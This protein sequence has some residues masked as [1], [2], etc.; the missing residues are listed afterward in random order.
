MN[1]K[2]LLYLAAVLCL[3][4]YFSSCTKETT[5]TP[6]QTGTGKAPATP[7]QQR[8]LDLVNNARTTGCQCGA[9]YYPA[10]AAVTWHAELEDAAKLHSEYMNET[11][12]LSHTGRNNSDAGTRITAAGYQWQAYGENIAEGY[13]TE[14]DVMNAWLSSPGHCANIMDG[15]FKEMGVATSGRFW[16]Q[17]F[18]T[19]Q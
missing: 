15:D 12:V 9:T 7:S 11:G 3:G 17:V 2:H 19:H 5:T 16:T 8:L 14:E 1:K 4:I 6:V 13:E 18:A 10:V